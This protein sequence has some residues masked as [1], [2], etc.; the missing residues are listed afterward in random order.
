MAVVRYC[1]WMAVS[2][3][4]NHPVA[5]TFFTG[6]SST[7][8]GLYLPCSTV[9][10]SSQGAFWAQ[11][12]NPGHLM[13]ANNFRITDISTICDIYFVSNWSTSMVKTDKKT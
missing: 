4:T 10:D 13:I 6:A 1:I 7:E 9:G 2:G 12:Y 3:L 8:T 5:S 11:R